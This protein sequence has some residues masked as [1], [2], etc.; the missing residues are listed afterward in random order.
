M[1]L[2]VSALLNAFF[3]FQQIMIYRDLDGLNSRIAS[4]PQISQLQSMGQNIVND[5]VVFGQKQPAIYSVLQK[6]GV[7]PPA[8]ASPK[9]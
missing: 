7:N 3:V 1:V 4:S 9:R 5:L 2:G 6:Y 8:A